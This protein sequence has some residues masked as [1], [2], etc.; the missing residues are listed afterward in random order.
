MLDSTQ[1]RNP[2]D[3]PDGAVLVV[4]SGQTGIQLAEEMHLADIRK[5]MRKPG[6]IK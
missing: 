6:S 5:M 2:R 3:L 4:G 1:Y